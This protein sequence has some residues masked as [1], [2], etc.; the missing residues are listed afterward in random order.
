MLRQWQRGSSA[1]LQLNAPENE[2]V[3]DALVDLIETLL[4][5]P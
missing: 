4:R 1:P 2:Q 3:V 5:S